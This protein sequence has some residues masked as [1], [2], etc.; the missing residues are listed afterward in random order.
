[1]YKYEVIQQ[2]TSLLNS[3]EV[4]GFTNVRALAEVGD[5][6]DMGII[7]ESVSKQEEDNASD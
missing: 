2:I 4:R 7:K 3:I 5:F 1:M 6:I